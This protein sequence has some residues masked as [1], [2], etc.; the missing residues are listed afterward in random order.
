MCD[1]L[2]QPEYIPENPDSDA[3]PG[4]KRVTGEE[5][6]TKVKPCQLDPRSMRAMKENLDV[7]KNK[8]PELHEVLNNF[9]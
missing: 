6:W 5:S 1:I 2:L 7:D 3:V 8:S 4:T 9:D